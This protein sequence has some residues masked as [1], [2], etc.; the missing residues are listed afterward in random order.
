MAI[1]E[2]HPETAQLLLKKG[3][4]VNVTCER[5]V[6]CLH[7]LMRWPT[8]SD[9]QVRLVMQLV[10]SGLDVNVQSDSGETPLLH[11]C[12][13]RDNSLPMAKYLLSIGASAATADLTGLAPLHVAAE[14]NNLELARLLIK[15]GAP[16]D[17]VGPAGIPAMVAMRRRSAAVIKEL[18]APLAVV[19]DAIYERIFRT[20]APADLYHAMA[21]CS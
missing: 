5:G 1:N 15:Y 3:A 7:L 12:R 21:A 4:S 9:V 8:Y 14:T 18:A 10:G 6:T 16:L 11:L 13:K 19:P 2:R 20:L 17:A